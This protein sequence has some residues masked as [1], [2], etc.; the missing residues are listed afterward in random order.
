MRVATHYDKLANIGRDLVLLVGR[1][2]VTATYVAAVSRAA[3]V[4]TVKSCA[5]EVGVNRPR[6]RTR[7]CRDARGDPLI[8]RGLSLACFRTGQKQGATRGARRACILLLT[9]Q[10]A[11]LLTTY[12][13]CKSRATSVM[14]LLD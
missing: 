3:P 12:E 7:S 14:S 1:F 5:M 6:M 8:L 13:A 4:N 9:L 10:T 2:F 11:V